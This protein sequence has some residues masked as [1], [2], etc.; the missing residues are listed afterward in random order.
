M[1]QSW[2]DAAPDLSA[3]IVLVTGASRGVGRGIART[4]GSAGATV[5]VT[6]KTSIGHPA[7]V[8]LPG[9]I[10]STAAEVSAVGGRGFALRCDH[11]C[12]EEVRSVINRII[13]E[14]GRIDI[15]VNNAWAGYKELQR[16]EDH[17]EDKFWM[18]P[19]SHWDDMFEVGVRSH[20]VTSALV[21]DSMVDRRSGL[22]VN[23]SYYAGASYHFNA[24]Y[25]VAKAA[26]D[27]LSAD[28]AHE[29]KEYNVASIALWPGTVK[30]EMNVLQYEQNL[31]DAE[32][33][34]F[35]GMGVVAL[36]ADPDIISKSG[37]IFK[38]RELAREYNFRDIDGTLPPLDRGL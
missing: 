7:D 30:T 37:R 11:R 2:L 35:V 9:T 5:Y 12:D 17:F 20:Y 15:L 8:P 13:A 21:A 36:A 27:R 24:A 26:V 14:A 33:P 16:G 31:Q 28:M 22:I 34:D 25:G 4:L 1:Q 38:T 10:E 18:L 3:R 29:L 6:G 32:T 23:V 19:L